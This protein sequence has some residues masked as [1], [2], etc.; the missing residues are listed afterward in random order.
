MKTYNIQY[1]CGCV[2]EMRQNNVLNLEAFH[3]PTG[4]NKDCEEH[5][6]VEEV[7]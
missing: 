1:S 6:K 5:K 7:L 4:N 3:K 2:H